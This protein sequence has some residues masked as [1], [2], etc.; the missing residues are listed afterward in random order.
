[1][2]FTVSH[3]RYLMGELARVA[4]GKAARGRVIMAHLGNGASLAAVLDG[5]SII[6]TS[7]GFTPTG[8]VPMGTRSGDLDPGVASA[9]MKTGRLSIKQFDRL[10]N[11]ESGL[12]REFPETSSDMRDLIELA[13][14]DRCPRARGCRPVL[15]S[16]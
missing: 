1:M 5:K 4:G 14:E 12:A 15:L 2:V 10:V 3:M 13:S 7:M 6:N 16:G 8:G 11:H 9:L